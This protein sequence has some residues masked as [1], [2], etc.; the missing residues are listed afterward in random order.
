MIVDSSKHNMLA[1]ADFRSRADDG[2]DDDI[3]NGFDDVESEWDDD[4]WE[5]DYNQ[6]DSDDY[7]SPDSE[8]QE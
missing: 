7:E 3:E 2:F 5:D 4:E 8:Y 1:Y 6:Y